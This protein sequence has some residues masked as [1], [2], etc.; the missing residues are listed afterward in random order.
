LIVKSFNFLCQ[1][2]A[3]DTQARAPEL[4]TQKSRLAAGSLLNVNVDLNGDYW[5]APTEC[6]LPI[7][8]CWGIAIIGGNV[9]NKYVFPGSSGICF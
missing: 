3:E 9:S 6:C 8:G 2:S 1:T 4:Q 7:A 5:T